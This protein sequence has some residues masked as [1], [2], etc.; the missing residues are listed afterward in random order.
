MFSKELAHD[1]VLWF[2]SSSDLDWPVRTVVELSSRNPLSRIYLLQ[3]G[4][5]SIFYHLSE[6][7]PTNLLNLATS[8]VLIGCNLGSALSSF[9]IQLVT[10]LAPSNHLL[11]V[12][13]GALMVGTGVFA[14]QLLARTK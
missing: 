7:I 3:Y 10:P 9:F 6:K 5:T 13:I 8:L 12:W 4:V 14:S 1:H 2:R 11:F